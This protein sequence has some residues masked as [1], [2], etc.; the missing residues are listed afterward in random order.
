MAIKKNKIVTSYSGIR[1]ERQYVKYIR[2]K[3]YIPNEECFFIHGQWYR[4]NSGKIIYDYRIKRW[5]L[6][7]DGPYVV[8]IV[9]INHDKPSD[10]FITG[11]FSP[12]PTDINVAVGKY[13]HKILRC[14][15][16][17][18]LKGSITFKESPMDLYYVQSLIKDKRLLTMYTTI[19]RIGNP[20]THYPQIPY[21]YGVADILSLFVPKF[22]EYNLN[23]SIPQSARKYT[24]KEYLPYTF[25]VEFET[26][27]GAIPQRYLFQYGLV[28]CRDGSIAG[29]EYATIPLEG[30]TGIKALY[31]HTQLLQQFC[32][33][34]YTDSVHIHLGGYP[35]T[36]KSIMA[37]YK[38]CVI[39]QNDIYK[40]SP[41]AY[42]QTSLFKRRDYCNPLRYIPTSTTEPYNFE[43]LYNVLLGG[44]QHT[45]S[46]HANVTTHNH[47]RDVSG[48]HKWNVNERYKVINFVPL[49]WGTRGTIEFRSHVP[50]MSFT[51]ITYWLY[52]CSAILQ[53][54][55][56]N[57]D[58]LLSRL[59]KPMKEL[60]LLDIITEIYPTE[61]ANP[62]KE[63][64]INRHTWYGS[65][66]DET[67]SHEAT[68]ENQIAGNLTPTLPSIDLAKIIDSKPLI[69]VKND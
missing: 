11:E 41:P 15:D 53:Y 7:S 52:I 37:L 8:G 16:K 5:R 1:I 24:T 26:T 29:F 6:I 44:D 30:A 14:I 68:T 28:P 59:S 48:R 66:V 32:R 27:R 4:I 20:S 3:Y 19:P 51:K 49:I 67:G 9:N 21:E 62:I 35:R 2:D 46:S 10:P 55:E 45:S 23:T 60:N 50:T 63:Y 39:I 25:G 40:L 65:S 64:I 43:K 58:F 18:L 34:A 61:L 42:K 47:P 12:N 17:N 69:P 36:K 13:Q 38:L 54:A 31:K 56:R 33:I 57:T 22:K